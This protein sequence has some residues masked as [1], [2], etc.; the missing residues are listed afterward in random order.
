MQHH[1]V[2]CA[3]ITNKK[4]DVFS[5][6]QSYILPYIVSHTI[7]FQSSNYILLVTQK[8]LIVMVDGR[9]LSYAEKHFQH[10]SHVIVRSI[11]TSSLFE[12]LNLLLLQDQAIVWYDDHNTTINELFSYQN[13]SKF[14]FVAIPDNVLRA[15]EHRDQFKKDI[16]LL[17]NKADIRIA[18]I[19]SVKNAKLISSTESVSWL[20][21]IRDT[22]NGYSMALNGILLVM[23]AEY[24][25]KDILFQNNNTTDIF[26]ILYDIKH[27]SELPQSIITLAENNIKIEI[28]Y[29]SLS[30][31]LY[32]KFATITHNAEYS[33]IFLDTI[34]ASRKLKA[35][36]T[37]EELENIKIA[38]QNDAIAF[39][40]FFEFV[41][42][43]NGSNATIEE[44]FSNALHKYKSAQQHYIKESFSTISALNENAAMPHYN[45][46]FSSDIS[47]SS[48]AYNNQYNLYLIDAGSQYT[49]GT[50][51][52]TRTILVQ[53]TN[54]KFSESDL[55]EVKKHFTLVL[56]SHIMLASA[57]FPKGTTGAQL[58]SLARYHVWQ[59]HLDYQ[60]STGH[61]VG[62]ALNVHEGPYYISS[63]CNEAIT[64][65]T[66]LSIEP[67][68][69]FPQKYGIRIENL[70]YVK[71]C[72]SLSTTE[73]SMLQEQIHDSYM[74]FIPLTIIPFDA[75]LIEYSMLHEN[76]IAWLERYNKF[77]NLM[78]I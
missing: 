37:Q 21:G 73:K 31:N 77:I 10:L 34:D 2:D 55:I 23:P 20:L 35:I 24:D 44:D 60:H 16:L 12:T 27:I 58:D 5:S 29:R 46:K 18:Q 68:L 9:Y 48:T 51:D 70:Y 71:K 53:S 76:E 49:C 1:C 28:E 39:D 56:K 17:N 72:A 54:G 67:A 38:H 74:C 78:K 75:T 32:N 65:N 42:T 8:E 13:F 57:I 4:D 11:M 15:F 25:K 63:N 43:F 7:N 66:I 41:S 22:E 30:T 62:F 69:Y 59:Q 52:V 36:K 61:G 3:I 45:H 47:P 33:E 6:A 40:K 26:N 14:E 19:R 50:T 64:E